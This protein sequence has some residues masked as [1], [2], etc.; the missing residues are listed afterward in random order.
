MLQ[1]IFDNMDFLLL[2]PTL[3][4]K[5]AGIYNQNQKIPGGKKQELIDAAFKLSIANGYGNTTVGDICTEAGAAKS[6]FFIISRP[7]MRY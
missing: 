3:V 4:S 6:T 7:R 5:G 1:F 2:L